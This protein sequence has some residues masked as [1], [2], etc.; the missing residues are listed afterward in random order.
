[1]MNNKLDFIQYLQLGLDELY[2]V[3]QKKRGTEIGMGRTFRPSCLHAG[4]TRA[5]RD[6]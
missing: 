6:P 1:M 3:G 2:G 5:I 4:V